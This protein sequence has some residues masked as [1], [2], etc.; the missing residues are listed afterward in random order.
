MPGEHGSKRKHSEANGMPKL[1]KMLLTTSSNGHH[2]NGSN[3]T[4]GTTIL[5]PT[6]LLPR[7]PV[8]LTS[9]TIAQN[10]TNG[11]HRR[12]N[13]Q[14]LRNEVEAM[15][16]SL[17]PEPHQENVVTN[18][19]SIVKVLPSLP[20]TPVPVSVAQVMEVNGVE[21]KTVILSNK[22]VQHLQQTNQ[23][24]PT[25]ILH[26]NSHGQ[27]VQQQQVVH[28]QPPPTSVVSLVKRNDNNFIVANGA[29]KQPTL[30]LANGTRVQIASATNGGHGGQQIQIPE[31]ILPEG[32]SDAIQGIPIE[33]ITTVA[34][35]NGVQNGTNGD[36]CVVENE[37]VMWGA[38]S[39]LGPA[40]VVEAVEPVTYIEEGGT[41]IVYSAS[42]DNID[43]DYLYPVT[44]TTATTSTEATVRQSAVRERQL[45]FNML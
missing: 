16:A 21:K 41:Q 17:N 39:N 14:E 34:S 10:T 35:T 29:G 36:T 40:V 12:P 31:L 1:K 15:M 44:T 7:S 42:M 22:T 8:P 26:Q 38:A 6:D 5:D 19:S 2:T 24:Q 43:Y 30:I 27:V 32:V 18:G 25:T 23:Q 45:E 9:T 37:E 3:G 20:N 33:V 13:T 11:V 28:H 4:N